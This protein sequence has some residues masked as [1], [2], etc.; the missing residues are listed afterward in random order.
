[1]SLRQMI[2]G[3]SS[4]ERPY[5]EFNREER[6]LAGI[7][8]H[9]LALTGLRERALKALECD[10]KINDAEFG[11]YLEYSYPRD[12][13]HSK[14]KE[15]ETKSV[16][17][18]NNWKRETILRLLNRSDRSIESSFPSLRGRTAAKDFNAFF[19]EEHRCSHEYIQS[20]ANWSL[21]RL[22][23]SVPDNDALVDACVLKWAFR[24][25]PDIVIHTDN[26]HAVC[27]E[28]KLE[29]TEGTYP[30][31]G[32]ERKILEKRRLYGRGDFRFPMRQRRL[33]EILMKDLLGLESI[34]WFITTRD[35]L[36]DRTL[37]WKELLN[38]LSPLPELPLYMRVALENAERNFA[39]SL[40]PS[41]PEGE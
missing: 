38:R 36:G 25:K 17:T 26:Q 35:D 7:L 30:A 6:H 28:L 14:S 20:P 37:A 22:A 12:A 18:A 3:A 23:D 31:A 39:R 24:V 15:L 9:I 19:I 29:S 34:F 10:W 1:M 27:L 41:E 2:Q 8:F 33:Q 11:V 13:W 16:E 4:T 5:Y 21:K 40:E 32:S